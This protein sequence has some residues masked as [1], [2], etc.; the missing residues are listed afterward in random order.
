MIVTESN[1]KA[2]PLM[3]ELAY[4]HKIPIFYSINS[5]IFVKAF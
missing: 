5:L 3:N 4:I 1:K 2:S